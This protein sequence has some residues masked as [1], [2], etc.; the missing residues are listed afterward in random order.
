[1][2]ARS[3]FVASNQTRG[4]RLINTYNVTQDQQQIT[5]DLP[6][7]P[8][9]ESCMVRISGTFAITTLFT[10]VRNAAAYRFLKRID[11]LINSNA[12]LDSVSGPQLAQLYITRRNYPALVNPSGFTVAAGY[13]F[14][15]TFMLDRA[16]MDM[17]RPKDS[18]LK[19]DVGVANNQLRIQLG[20]LSDMFTGAGVATYTSVTASVTVLDYQ[21]AKGNDGNTPYP[22]FY[23]KRN[24]QTFNLAGAGAAQQ[25]KI[26]TGNRLRCISIIVRDPA[27]NEPNAA[28][29][30]RLRV[31]RAGDTRYDTLTTELAR[32]N[33]MAYGVALL[34]GQ[35]V[36]DFANNGQLGVRYSEFW[37]IP[38]SADTYL[39]VD[40][41]GA[42][43]IDM[44]TIEG[45][46]LVQNKF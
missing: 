12:T 38:S 34:T 3:N 18:M 43:T 15:V 33:Q 19:T 37:P 5:V 32:Q 9:I 10:A 24:G 30:T 46:D 25:I 20:A 39:Y 45:V 16:L 31:S 6:R 22:M 28:L 14:D 8:A 26:N 42:C 35:F 13:S 41:T 40:T 36:I 11:W 21:E 23:V 29:V 17:M 27:T 2:G 44:A 7:G 1:M 4:M